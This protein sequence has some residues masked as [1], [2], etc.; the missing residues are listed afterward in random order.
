MGKV[1][2]VRP[3]E[4][5]AGPTISASDDLGKCRGQRWAGGHVIVQE[6]LD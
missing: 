3:A 5:L 6:R 2:T 1:W 4:R